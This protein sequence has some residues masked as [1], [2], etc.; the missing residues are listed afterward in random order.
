MINALNTKIL[1]AI[2]ASL[3]LISGLLIR[4]HQQVAP[5]AGAAQRFN[6][7]GDA[8]AQAEKRHRDEYNAAIKEEKKQDAAAPDHSQDVK[9]YI[10]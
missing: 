7:E 10:P 3:A 9:H 5:I 1:L 2:L 8:Q 4:Q 6:Q